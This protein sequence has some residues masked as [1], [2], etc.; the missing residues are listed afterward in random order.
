MVI[1]QK[2]KRRTTHPM[3]FIE[4]P[5]NGASFSREKKIDIFLD[6]SKKQRS[7]APGAPGETTN[8]VPEQANRPIGEDFSRREL[9]NQWYSTTTKYQVCTYPALPE[10]AQN[11]PRGVYFP[12]SPKTKG[13]RGRHQRQKIS[14]K[15]NIG[16]HIQFIS[17]GP[18]QRSIVFEG[19]KNRFFS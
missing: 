14:Q 17:R 2:N 12:K 11:G 19:G 5:C 10:T 1:S 8:M 16:R 9:T 4:V 15:I 3:A 13:A 18:M 6:F 7:S